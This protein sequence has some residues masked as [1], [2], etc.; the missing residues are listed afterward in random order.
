MSDHTL[1]DFIET[2]SHMLPQRRP[3]SVFNHYGRAVY[4]MLSSLMTLLGR[5]CRNAL[6]NEVISIEQ[7]TSSQCVEVVKRGG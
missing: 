4:F 6:L 2:T 5:F 3:T 1:Q 7:R